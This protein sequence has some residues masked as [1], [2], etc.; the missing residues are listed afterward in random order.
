MRLLLA[1]QSQAGYVGEVVTLDAPGESF[2]INNF[3]VHAL[4]P[5]GTTFGYSPKL[6]PWLR[7]NLHRFDFVVVNGLWQ[8][9]GYSAWKEIKGKKPYFVFTHGMLDPYFKKRY[10]LKHLKK[11]VYWF[12]SEYW[13]LKNAT[14]VLF[15][16]RAEARLAKE[17]FMLHDWNELV[18]PYGSEQP[19]ADTPERR[20]SF[21]SQFPEVRGKKFLLFLG[22]IHP[23]KGCDLL[24]CSFAKM[25]KVD[26]EMML[27]M[28]G[29]DQVGWKD[30]LDKIAQ[31]NGVAHKIVWT[32]MLTGDPKWGA[33]YSA[34]AFVLPSHQEN[35]GIAVAESLGCGV[36]VLLSDKINIAEEIRDDGAGLM[37]PDTQD[38]SDALL[39]QWAKMP[40]EK[41]AAMREQTFKTFDERY[42][43]SRAG[44]VILKAAEEAVHGKAAHEPVR[45]NA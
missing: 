16:T 36:P 15:T 45:A 30:K 2:L 28:A 5:V 26:P 23:K 21:F 39:L 14:K 6:R 34:D 24:V 12:L 35:F 44:E 42:R 10:P 38:G 31:E 19:P 9:L 33:M 7:E 29:P 41:K 20:E 13:V 17:S 40:A 1:D 27:V 18:V 11:M 4:G 3:P 25:A 32:G 22:R 8:Y 37:E 43:M